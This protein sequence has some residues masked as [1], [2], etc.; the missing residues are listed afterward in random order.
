MSS[1]ECRHAASVA[2]ETAFVDQLHGLMLWPDPV[3]DDGTRMVGGLCPT[4]NSTLTIIVAGDADVVRDMER[5][6]DR[7]PRGKTLAQVAAL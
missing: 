2:N 6:G 4:C 3:D 1:N 7:V 5:L